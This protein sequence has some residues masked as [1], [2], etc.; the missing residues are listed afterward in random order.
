MP[1]GQALGGRAHGLLGRGGQA[2]GRRLLDHLLVTTLHRAVAGAER[3]GTRGVR[4]HL[5]LDVAPGLDV[6]LDEDRAVAEGRRGL[7]PRRLDLGLEPVQGAYDAHAA[8]AATGRRLHQQREVGL[9]RLVRGRED[10]NAGLLGDLLGADL[11]AHGLDGLGRRS[12]P[13]QAGVD[14]G[15]GEGGVLG[16]EAVAG[17]D[18]VGTGPARRLDDQVGAE[19]G[20]GGRVAGEP[21]GP[22]GL[23]HERQPGVGV[24]VDRHGLDAE[25]SAGGEDATGDLA[26]VGDQQ[27]S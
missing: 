12:D 21:D 16:Q 2:G 26:A 22:V 9:G 19:V 17:M 27:V 6:G 1:L 23:G 10:G 14:D 20:V 24:G 3:P 4:H 25:P 5:H 8:P 18:R 11:V 7:R 15:P 13:G